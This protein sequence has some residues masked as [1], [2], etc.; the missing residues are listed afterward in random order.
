MP[1]DPAWY[2]KAPSGIADIIN[3]DD[4]NHARHRRVLSHAFSADA[5]RGQEPLLKRYADLLVDRLRESIVSDSTPQDIS[6]WF[7]WATF[8]II[9]HLSFGVPFGCLQEKATHK[10][11]KLLFQGLKA[12]PLHYVTTY[13][14]WMKYVLSMLTPQSAIKARGEYYDF[15]QTRTQNRIDTETQYEDFMTEILKHN[16]EKG[17]EIDPAEITGNMGVFLT[18]GSETSASTLSAA[19]YCLLRIPDVMAKLQAE[20]RGQ[21]KTY[22]D[23]TIDSV[24]DSPYLVAVLQESLRYFSPVPTGFQR[25]VP[26]GGEVVSNYYLPEGTALCVSMYPLGRSKRNFK[27]PDAFVPERWMGDERYADDQRDAMQAF[28]FG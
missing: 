1:K 28:S 11:I 8:D 7:H 16:G 2:A 9:A 15:V 21:F 14:P 10:Y 20:I 26:A 6:Q 13:W 27:D 25:R 23:I 17:V 18:A 12:F 24:N 5:L 22:N 19:V 3:A 4:Q